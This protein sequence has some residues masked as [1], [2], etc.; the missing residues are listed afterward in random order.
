LILPAIVGLESFKNL[1]HYW[2]N[3]AVSD[4]IEQPGYKVVLIC[5]RIYTAHLRTA[6]INRTELWMTSNAV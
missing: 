3:F 1:K 5:K 6:I 2:A 4:Q